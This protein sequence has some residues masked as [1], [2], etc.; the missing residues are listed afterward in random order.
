MGKSAG[1]NNRGWGGCGVVGSCI[2][3]DGMK[4]GDEFDGDESNGSD[5]GSGTVRAGS[6]SSDLD[7]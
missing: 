4:R 6:P 5:G 7:D 2:A 3:G 1:G